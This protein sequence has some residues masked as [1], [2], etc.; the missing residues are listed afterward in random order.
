MAVLF[1]LIKTSNALYKIVNF[2]KILD[3]ATFI[4]TKN[5]I[6]NSKKY[7]NCAKS[8]WI[9]VASLL[10]FYCIIYNVIVTLLLFEIYWHNF[11]TFYCFRF[12]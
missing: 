4:T 11:Y 10:L 9:K 2:S 8:S 6:Y 5:K 7:K 12:Y 3:L 1:D